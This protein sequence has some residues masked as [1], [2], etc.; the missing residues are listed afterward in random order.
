MPLYGAPKM[1]FTWHAT[2]SLRIEV[3]FERAKRLTRMCETVDP[4]PF[5]PLLTGDSMDSMDSAPESPFQKIFDQLSPAERPTFL[6]AL[7][8]KERKLLKE[9]TTS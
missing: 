6:R 3:D 9:R 2:A 8:K 1:A 7:P 4:N 5:G